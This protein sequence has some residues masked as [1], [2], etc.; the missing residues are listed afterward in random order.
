MRNIVKDYG[1]LRL[2]TGI[3]RETR[4]NLKS[5]LHLH[6]ILGNTLFN[7]VSQGCLREEASGSFTEPSRL[8]GERMQ[9][10]GQA[11]AGVRGGL[12]GGKT[13]SVLPKTVSVFQETVSVLP[14]LRHQHETI[15][16]IWRVYPH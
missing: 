1:F 5:F 15:K 16:E 12:S 13:V 2:Y 4:R 10:R 8:A 9:R 11:H 14:P 3:G 7:K 6:A